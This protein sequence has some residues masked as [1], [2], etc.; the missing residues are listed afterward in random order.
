MFLKLFISQTAVMR[1]FTI[2]IMKRIYGNTLGILIIILILSFSSPIANNQLRTDGYYFTYDTLENTHTGEI[3]IRYYPMILFPDSTLSDFYW[4]NSKESF[5]NLINSKS[6]KWT[7]RFSKFGNYQIK[8]D[9]I[10]IHL[11]T[12]ENKWFGNKRGPIVDAYMKG[13]IL[14]DTQYVVT[15]NI[16]SGDTILL[17][18]TFNFVRFELKKK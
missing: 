9:S 3:L 10:Y 11:R 13:I 15:Q 7:K 14:N 4:Q 2:T 5:E 1:N 18:T 17:S 6:Y 8:G 12:Y 16:F